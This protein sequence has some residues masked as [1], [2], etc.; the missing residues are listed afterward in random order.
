LPSRSTADT[1]GRAGAV[2]V[3]ESQARR[4]ELI[5]LVERGRSVHRD[6]RPEPP[7]AQVRPVADLSVADAH[8]VAS[9]VT[10]HVRE[11]D[12]LA[13]GRR[14]HPRPAF[15]VDRPSSGLGRPE[16]VLAER[17]IPSEPLVGGDE[18][19]GQPVA[20]QVDEADVGVAPRQVRKRAERPE[21]LPA[22]DLAPLEE[23]GRRA[24]ERNHV[25]LPVAGEI[26]Q[27]LPGAELGS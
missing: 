19:V 17:R 15:L 5:R 9:A 4:I 26:E 20:G 6:L 12:R 16:P 22:I 23:A 10:R 24:L 8:D 1:V 18:D 11:I 13:L 27:P 25:E 2:D 14:Q 7:V 21:R 3:G